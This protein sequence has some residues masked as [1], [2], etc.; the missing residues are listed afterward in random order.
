MHK[1]PQ[2]VVYWIWECEKYEHFEKSLTKLDM[3]N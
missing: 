2:F 3:T 1:I